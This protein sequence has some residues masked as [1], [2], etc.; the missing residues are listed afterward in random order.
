MCDLP[1]KRYTSLTFSIVLDHVTTKSAIILNK[2]FLYIF[3]TCCNTIE[4]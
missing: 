4:R 2:V 1:E 3:N